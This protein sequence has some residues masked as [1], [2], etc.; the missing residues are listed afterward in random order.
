MGVGAALVDLLL[1]ES[2]DFV[3][4]LG[5]EK[6]GMNF[7]ETT[8]IENA[9]K[10]SGKEYEVVPGGSACNT[11]VGIGMLGGESKFI[12]RIGGDEL[13]GVF[14]DGIKKANVEASLINSDE[15]TGRVLSVVTPDA[16]RTMFPSLGASASLSDSDF[17]LSDFESAAIV[18]V[19]GYLAFNEPVFRSVINLANEAGAKI[20]L[21]LASFDV[22]NAKRELLDEYINKGMIQILIANEDEARAYTGKEEQ[23]ALAELAPKCEIAIVKLGAK[24]ALIHRDGQT[25]ETPA[26][27]VK[28][29][30]TTGAGDLWAAGFLYGL[31]NEWGIPDAAKLGASCG[32]EVVQIMGAVIPAEGWSRIQSC[33][34]DISAAKA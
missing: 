33:V 11:L 18:H 15:D 9:L 26:Q 5:V 4:S 24:G 8:M 21:D 10:R 32:A 22:V 23:E 19:E 29:I 6:G 13:G 2:D 14:A 3:A 25:Y 27:V 7:A 28:A 16:Q 31:V 30:D 34:Q 17:S 1:E 12:G 20:S